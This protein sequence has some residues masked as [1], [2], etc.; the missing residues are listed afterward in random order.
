[1]VALAH[2]GDGAAF[3]FK[4][5]WACLLVLSGVVGLTGAL[6]LEKK[7]AGI[8][9]SLLASM[10]LPLTPFNIFTDSAALATMDNKYYYEYTTYVI[11]LLCVVVESFM[12]VVEL[13][14]ADHYLKSFAFLKSQI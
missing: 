1:M 6:T 8:G 11:V 3:T 2:G 9:L 10:A 13:D 4:W 12:L 7:Y 5:V 14:K